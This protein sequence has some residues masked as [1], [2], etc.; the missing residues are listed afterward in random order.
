MDLESGRY[1]GRAE[2]ISPHTRVF[3]K[4]AVAVGVATFRDPAHMLSY[5]YSDGKSHSI[6]VWQNLKGLGLCLNGK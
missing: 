6:T 1:V 2:S 4:D 5:Y 3:F